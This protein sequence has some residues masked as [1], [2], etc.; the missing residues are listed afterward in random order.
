MRVTVQ[1]NTDI[2]PR[3]RS[4][5]RRNVHK[6]KA[7]ASAHKIDNQRPLRIA[8]AISA[9]NRHR[10]TN[11]AKFIQDAFRAN[12]AEM[13]NLIRVSRQD[14]DFLGQT[15]MCIGQNKNPQ[16][17]AHLLNRELRG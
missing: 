5:L 6:A 2:F 17:L 8:V 13:P 16:W 1:D 7:N 14:R 4:G 12:I 11:R 9:H 15:I 10:R 3:K